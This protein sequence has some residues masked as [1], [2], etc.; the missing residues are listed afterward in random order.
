[1]F[2]SY[3]EI[4]FRSKRQ[5]FTQLKAISKKEKSQFFWKEDEPIRAEASRI[6]NI[7]ANLQPHT[8]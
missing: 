4:V 8:N 6:F 1:M 3:A 2:T 5:K 7:Q